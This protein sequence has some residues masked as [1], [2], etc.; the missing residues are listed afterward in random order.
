LQELEQAKNQIQQMAA[1][2][3]NNESRES[4]GFKNF[5]IMD[6]IS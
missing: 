6:N 3:S 4:F 1:T 2:D 5:S